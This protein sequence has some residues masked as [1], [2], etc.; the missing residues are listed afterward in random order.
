MTNGNGQITISR[1][2]I[3]WLISIAASLVAIVIGIFILC[4][5]ADVYAAKIFNQQFDTRFPVLMTPYA[6]TLE[7]VRQKTEAN[8]S[9]IANLCLAVKVLL[10]ARRQ[11]MTWE[12]KQTIVDELVK[13]DNISYDSAYAILDLPTNKR[14]R[15]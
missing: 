14:T 12:Q 11:E 5:R 13:N 9:K 1:K 4:D 15:R 7:T 6:V 8:N 2:S 3:T 10:M